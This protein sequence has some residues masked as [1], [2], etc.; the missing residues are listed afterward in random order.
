[1]SFKRFSIA[2]LSSCAGT[3]LLLGYSSLAEVQTTISKRFS[4]T[5]GWTLSFAVLLLSGF[6][7]YLGRFRRWNS[8]DVLANPLQL[9]FD[10][11]NGLLNPTSH[12]RTV[13]FSLIYGVALLLG[14]VALRVLHSTDRPNKVQLS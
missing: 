3:G 4:A 14:Y 6:G 13:A 7:I 12:P 9:F 11:G 8:W 2:L 1:M 5:V 10:I